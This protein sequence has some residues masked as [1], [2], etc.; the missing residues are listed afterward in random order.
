MPPS[1]IFIVKE[2][3]IIIKQEADVVPV[4]LISPKGVRKEA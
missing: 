3:Q 1:M 2:E 4:A